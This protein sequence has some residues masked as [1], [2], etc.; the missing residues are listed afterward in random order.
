MYEE[1]KS[2]IDWKGIFLKVVIAFL[3]VLIAVKGYS[4]LKGNNDK[5]VETTTKWRSSISFSE[6]WA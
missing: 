5:K 2:S 1:T 6:V 4:T 3:I